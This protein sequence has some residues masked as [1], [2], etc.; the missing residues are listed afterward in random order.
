MSANIRTVILARVSGK[1]QEDGYSFDSQTKLLQAYC[2][3]NDL[4][5][6]KTF[7][8][9][10]TA[11]KQKSRKIFHE[12]LKYL[13]RNKIQNLAVEKSDRL[14][15]NLRDGVAVDDWLEDDASRILYSAKEKIRRIESIETILYDDKI[16]GEITSATYVAKCNKLMGDI[17]GLR[18]ELN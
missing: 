6:V 2:D 15:R 10:E 13:Y 12:L 4:L 8:I 14:T 11:S 18:V 9:A 17:P 3:N 16:A 7:K 1:D 5:V